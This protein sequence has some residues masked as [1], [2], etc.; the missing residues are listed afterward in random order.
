MEDKTDHKS[1]GDGGC[2]LIQLEYSSDNK[3]YTQ[4]VLV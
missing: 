3:E 1:I 2:S 4:A